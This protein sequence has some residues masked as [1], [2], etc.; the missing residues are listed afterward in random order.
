VKVAYPPILSRTYAGPTG[1]QTLETE[2]VTVGD[3]LLTDFGAFVSEQS[4]PLPLMLVSDH[5]TQRVAGATLAEALTAAGTPFEQVV[6]D[7]DPLK[8]D[9]RSLAVLQQAIPDGT[10][11][12]VACGS[13]TI[14][15]LVKLA[16]YERGIRYGVVA[17]AASMNGYTSTISAMTVGGLKRTLPARSPE[18]VLADLEVVRRAPAEMAGAGFADLLSKITAMADW[19]IAHQINGGWFS[20]EPHKL[21]ELAFDTVLKKS[22]CIGAADNAAIGA[23]THALILSGL[24]MAVAGSSSPASGGEHLIS[25]YWDMTAEAS[26][27]KPALH[28]AQVAIGTLVSATLHEKL[29]Q[30]QPRPVT[31][32]DR[33]QWLTEVSGRFEGAQAELVAREAALVYKSQ[34]QTDDRTAQLERIWE[35]CLAAAGQY[36]LP[37]GQLQQYF[38]EAGAPT[39]ISQIGISPDEM[40]AAFL[41]GREIRNRY[42]VL[43]LASDAGLLESLADEVLADSGVLG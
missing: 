41:H 26:G 4:L 36:L 3:Q 18:W 11:H 30:H 7:G 38:A 39:R 33:E 34:K 14:N 8:A 23:L 9:D 32:P 21:V 35:P 5:N 1:P 16:A 43:H 37:S 40:R 13:G 19:V 2:S 42:T 28:G 24:S 20:T 27:R 17:T 29:R 10:A 22:A 15:D 31:V 25:H 12:L 6:L